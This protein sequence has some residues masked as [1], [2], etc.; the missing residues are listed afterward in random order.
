MKT[1][2]TYSKIIL[3]F[4]LEIVF[5]QYVFAQNYQNEIEFD[6]LYMDKLYPGFTTNYKLFDSTERIYIVMDIIQRHYMDSAY[7]VIQI[8]DSI[9]ENCFS[10]ISWHIDC[11][12][13]LIEEI[14]RGG[15]YKFKLFLYD[16]L[17]PGVFYLQGE[18]SRE[19]YVDNKF[20]FLPHDAT[21]YEIA[22]TPNLKGLCYIK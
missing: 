2:D 9:Y 19:L 1:I 17:K 3:F 16:V 12:N 11:E 8:K 22:I 10:I 4:C 18:I 14:K 6:S 20:L 5:A 7:Y 21:K 15:Y 13:N